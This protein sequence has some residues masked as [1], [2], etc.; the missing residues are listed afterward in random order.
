VVLHR[1]ATRR[2]SGADWT[3]RSRADHPAA[4]AW[5]G[6]CGLG[7][8][9]RVLC[10]RGSTEP[11]NRDDDRAREFAARFS[12]SSVSGRLSRPRDDRVGCHSHV[13]ALERGQGTA[14]YVVCWW[15]RSWQQS[16]SGS[17]ACCG[18]RRRTGG[19]TR[20]TGDSIRRLDRTR[21]EHL[22]FLLGALLTTIYPMIWLVVGMTSGFAR[23][24]T[25]AQGYQATHWL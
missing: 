15:S 19:A 13:R 5:T 18:F 20:R 10:P 9:R 23:V 17:P 8:R 24:D 12:A 16:R 21:A 7:G 2:H 14:F 1:S 6:R 3:S 25:I 22:A 11:R 4:G